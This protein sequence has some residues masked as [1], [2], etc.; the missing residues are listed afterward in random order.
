ML[1]KYKIGFDCTGL[2]LFLIIMIPNFIWFGIPA[3]DDILRIKSATETV[4][5]IGS[6]FQVLMVISLCAVVNKDRTELKVS[7]ILIGC[8]VCILL[9]YLCWFCYYMGKTGIIVLSGLA[10]FPCAAFLLYSIDRKNMIAGLCT[11]VFTICHLIYAIV[12]FAI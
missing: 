10:V 11:G 2:I 9:Y 8:G 1:R 6:V 5:M 7:G 12:N 3:P 4:D